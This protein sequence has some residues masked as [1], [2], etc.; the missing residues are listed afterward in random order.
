MRA[1]RRATRV[2]VGV[3]ADLS[4]VV[5]LQGTVGPHL[6]IWRKRPSSSSRRKPPTWSSRRKPR[7]RHPAKA[8]ELVIPAKAPTSS[9]RRK[10]PTSSSRRKPPTSSS[11]RK[12]PTSSSRRKPGPSAFALLLLLLATTASRP[13]VFHSPSMASESLSLAC[14]R[15]SNHC[16]AGA[17][18]TAE[19]APKGRRARMP[20]VKRRAPRLGQDQ[21]R[22]L[23]PSA[24]S[25]A[26][27][28][29]EALIGWALAHR[30]WLFGGPLG[31]GEDAEEKARRGTRRTRVEGTGTRVG[32]REKQKIKMDPGFHRDD[33]VRAQTRVRYCL[34]RSGSFSGSDSI[35]SHTTRL[36]SQRLRIPFRSRDIM[37]QGAHHC[38]Q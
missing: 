33:E 38:A 2:G 11:R 32:Y 28:G 15:E 8:S 9:S 10:P 18:R 25:P 24:P 3:A 14:P 7:P 26:S 37:R 5:L 16:A 36:S 19:L 22:P 23:P 17:A 27:G 29:R 12:P 13:C 1:R 34:P 31:R 30:L 35:F 20:G 6:V 4:L 21:E